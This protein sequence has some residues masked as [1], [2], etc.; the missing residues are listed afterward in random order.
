MSAD[1]P[2]KPTEIDTRAE[3]TRLWLKSQPAVESFIRG[4]VFDREAREDLL[5]ATAEQASRSFDDYDRSRPFTAWVLG[6]ARYRILGHIRGRQR[7]RLR[8]NDQTL[9]LIADAAERVSGEMED[10]FDALEQCM[11]HLQPKHQ[12]LVRLRY[13]DGLK[14]SQ[15]AE[16]LGGSP[17]AVSAMIRR[18]RLALAE[19]IDKRLRMEAHR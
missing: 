7:E 3:L 5:Q 10:R 19:C 4:M 2:T 9:D 1:K 6:I 18:I 12:K 15:L 14:P 17:N 8:F 13:I 16:K 11:S